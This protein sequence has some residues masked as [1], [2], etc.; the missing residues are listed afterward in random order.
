RART[1]LRDDTA[2]MVLLES[3]ALELTATSGYDDT[4]PKLRV[5][6]GEGDI[7]RVAEARRGT[8]LADAPRDRGIPP[9]TASVLVI[10]VMAEGQLLGV[11]HVGTTERRQF[12]DN[13]LRLLQMVVDRAAVAIEGT[14]LE[15]AAIRSTL[16]ADDARRRLSLLADAGAVLSRQ[17]DDVGTMAD[18]IGEALVP[19]FADWFAFHRVDDTGPR[20]LAWRAGPEVVPVAGLGGDWSAAVT[21]AIAS[22][23]PVVAWGPELGAEQWQPAADRGLTSVLVVPVTARDLLRGALTFGTAGERRGLR[24][25]DV[26]TVVDLAARVAVAIERVLLGIETQRS[27][28]RAARN[29]TQLQRL[30]EAAFAVN[31]ALDTASLATVV[32]EQAARVLDVAAASVHLDDERGERWRV[33]RHGT[34]PE[35]ATVASADLTDA[36]GATVG[37]ITV[38]RAGAA[39]AAD[40]EAVLG[41][42]AQTASIALAN[43]KLYATVHGSETRLRALYDA[44]PVGIVELDAAGR[45]LRWNRAAEAIFAWPPFDDA[46]AGSVLAPEAARDAVAVAL[47]DDAPSAID[48][49]LGDVE[50]QLVAVPLRE[51]DGTIRGAVLAAVDLTERKHVAEQL[52][53]AQRMEAMARMAGGIAHDFNNVLMVITGYADLLLRRAIDDDVRSDIESMRAAAKRAA[54]FTRKLLT[55]SRRQMVQAQVVDVAEAIASLGTVLPVM[56]GEHITLGIHVEDP[57]PVL[58]DPLQFEQLVLNLAIN[59]KDAM[60]AGG[61]LT[62]TARSLEDDGTWTQLTVADTGEGMDAETVEHCFE[63]F[64][65]TK[66]RTKGT[67]LGLSTAYGVVTQAG[68]EIVAESALGVGTTFTIRLPAVSPEA[69]LVS[70]PLGA[71]GL[72]RILVVDDDP[73]VRAIVA[74]M[75]ELDG[76]EVLVAADGPSALRLLDAELDV[77]LTDVV[78]PG[79]R[80]TEL[81]TLALER[82]PTLRVV[83]MSSHVDDQ[84]AIAADLDDA[85]FLAK[86]F[87]PAALAD[88]LAAISGPLPAQDSTL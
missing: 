84:L 41:S 37:A 58:I 74:D 54:E 75:L 72:L 65:T 87:S 66:D 16:A 69:A 3:G 49:T 42:L 23:Q 78:M 53:Q 20:L 2:S 80:G 12:G 7:G 33:G 9:G 73:D 24:P 46:I 31:A 82:C 57:P 67:G 13:E 52:Q 81:A 55:I 59:A 86:P 17:F 25:G 29:A 39:F 68:G 47:T 30:T 85:L 19:T 44:S 51:R 28:V 14:R 62:I 43:A 4:A 79:M 8:A 34:D 70:P 50:A 11:L 40:E 32:S 21:A 18:A 6:I 76:H 35:R 5:A 83:L 22:G 1:V 36:A 10:P 61:T 27:A 88:T 63:P 45:A 26:T 64:F 60:P 15:R 71:G 77:L 56:L 38:A 48:V